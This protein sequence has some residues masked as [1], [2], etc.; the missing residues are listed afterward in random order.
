MKK[1][2]L[3]V[4]YRNRPE[5]LTE[6]KS[7]ITKYLDKTKIPYEVIIID[8]EEGKLF[9]RGTLLNIGHLYAKQ[10]GCDYLVFHDVDMIPVDVD[11]SFSDKPLHL[12]TN[13]NEDREMFDTY[14]GGV[15]MFPIET[16]E[17]INGFSNKYW[18][19]GYED[20][21]LLLRCEK[22]NVPLDEVKIKNHKGS[23]KSLKLNGI[24]AYV[25]GKNIFN[26]NRDLTLFVS[27]YP[28]ELVCEHTKESDTFS[29]FS[30]PG[31]DFAISYNSFA[32]YNFCTFGYQNN[33]LYVNSKIKTNYKTNICIRISHREKKVEVFQDGEFIGA[34]ERFDK[35]YTYTIEPF[36]YIGVGDPNRWKTP[37]FFKGQFDSLIYYSEALKTEEIYDLSKNYSFGKY[38]S[39]QSIKLH[40]DAKIVSGYKLV[41]LSGNFNDGEIVNCEITKELIDEYVKIKVPF[42]RE[43]SFLLLPHEEN[44]FSE[45]KWKHNDTRWNQLRYINE[46]SK[47]DGLLFDDGLS[48]FRF[49]EVSKNVVRNITTVKVLI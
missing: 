39:S 46:V 9:N 12:A 3:I 5:H 20:D 22:N 13:F 37:N 25:K 24:N 47:N 40:Y 2:G 18:G 10:L 11:Y 42:R 36:F 19:W 34:T 23:G 27:F 7:R 41:D 16:F 1:L 49:S 30:I 31:Y 28:E 14:F 17:K 48:D 21:D 33:V 26:F 4:P 32:R 38:P 6:F 35:L 43:S 15:T 45:N 44:G 8:Q 29:I